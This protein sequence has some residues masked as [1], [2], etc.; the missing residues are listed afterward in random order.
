[1]TGWIAN[2]LF[3]VGV[4]V[5]GNRQRWGFL[6]NLV[7]NGLYGVIGIEHRMWDLFAISVVMSGL[8]LWNWI[9]WGQKK[10]SPPLLLFSQRWDLANDVAT[11]CESNRAK[12]D[13]LGHVT[14]LQAL[15]VD[16][17]RPESK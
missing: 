4:Y 1:M 13:A 2:L 16:L 8:N 15:G 12:Q 17:R 6:C 3:V 11:W 5:L 14:A 10:P 9:K 7:A